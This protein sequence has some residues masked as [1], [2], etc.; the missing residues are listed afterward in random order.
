MRKIE[1]SMEISVSN[2]EW[3][4]G[5]KISKD[6]EQS[7]TIDLELLNDEATFQAVKAT[8]EREFKGAMEKAV[9]QVMQRMI[10]NKPD[11]PVP[12]SAADAVGKV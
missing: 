5:R 3:T 11:K 12:G 1:I 7:H 4:D 8:W 9:N 10:D 6:W 2:G